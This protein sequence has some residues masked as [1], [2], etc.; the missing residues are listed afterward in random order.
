MS[1]VQTICQLNSIMEKN[2]THSCENGENSGQTI[3]VL[4]S[5]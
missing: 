3:V 1:K 5:V 2:G 4:L